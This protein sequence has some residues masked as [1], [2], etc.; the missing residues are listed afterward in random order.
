MYGTGV[1]RSDGVVD[2][3]PRKIIVLS[4]VIRIK[5][6]I[7][8]MPP[9]RMPFLVGFIGI[10]FGYSG[11]GIEGFGLGTGC[12]MARWAALTCW[13]RVD[14]GEFCL[15]SLKTSN[16]KRLSAGVVPS[17]SVVYLQRRTKWR[18]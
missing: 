11:E 5:R 1:P 16:R 17:R 4:S 8:E 7:S 14:K 15:N 12:G 13:N 2:S 10:E 9:M 18:L 6:Q 3:R